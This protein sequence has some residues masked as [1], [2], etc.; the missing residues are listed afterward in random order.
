MENVVE[1]ISKETNVLC[2]IVNFNVDGQQYVCAGHVSEAT[3]IISFLE[4][5]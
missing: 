3:V 2:E 5:L 1:L 4:H